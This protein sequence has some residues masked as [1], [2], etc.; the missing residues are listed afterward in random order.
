MADHFGAA[1]IPRSGSPEKHVS[2]AE[3]Q[4]EVND[5]PI[6]QVRLTVP[7]T[8]DPLVPVLTFRT[9]VLGMTSCAILAFL[10]QFFGYRQN[11]LYI[12]SIS[13][14]II[15]LPLGRLMAATL[16]TA[17]IRVPFT[18]LSFSL[19]PGPFNLKEHVLITIFANAGSN[20]VY[21]VNIIT[22]VKAFYHRDLHPLAAYLL[23]QTTQML[24]YGWAGMFRK[25]LVDSP[26]MWWP[27][28]MVSISLFRALH[29]KEKRPKGGL[30]RLQFFYMVFISSFAYYLLPAYLF[31]SITTISFV[32]LIWKNSITAQQLGSGL[33]GLG[34]GSIGLDWSTIAGFLGS[35]LTYPVFA[36]V[37]IMA[38]FF[39]IVY[40]V[41]PTAYWLN[42]YEAKKF[43]FISSHTFDSTGHPYNISR[44]LNEKTFDLDEAGYNGYSK[45]Y[46]SVFFAM[47]YGLS[48]AT[49]T[50]TVSHVALF[51]GK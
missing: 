46:L 2:V 37:N 5:C 6:E 21:A 31:P 10:N 33:H 8:D 20:S 19:N 51:H 4:E 23:S 45:L 30:T 40:I 42:A 13:A 26:Y 49:L 50:A 47:T 24:G 38:G 28:S 18:K 12:S 3:G 43:P 27:S 44:V 35:P 14:Q 9:W 11:Q 1:E 29:E 7:I 36:I 22:I 41:V 32:C 34:I 25:I 48:F 39:I 16:P 17:Q 15:T